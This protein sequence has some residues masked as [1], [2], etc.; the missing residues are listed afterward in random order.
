MFALGSS[1]K[2]LVAAVQVSLYVSTFRHFFMRFSRFQ[3]R[4]LLSNEIFCNAKLFA[5]FQLHPV[6][7]QVK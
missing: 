4:T 7:Q 5:C 6:T 3:A 2:L 1:H